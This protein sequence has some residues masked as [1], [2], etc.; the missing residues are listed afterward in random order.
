MIEEW[1]TSDADQAGAAIAATN[2]ALDRALVDG[3]P[4]V[5]AAL[6]T[7]DAVLG[8]SGIADV[9]GRDAIAGFLAR[10]GQVRAVT[11]HAVHRDELIVM[12]NRAIE[13]AWFEET[14]VPHGG[15]PIQERGRLATDWRREAD[16]VWRIARLVISDL[17]IA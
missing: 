1:L 3:T 8:E 13:F 15:V 16:G 12:G 10:G 17:P 5:A 11:F 9:V 4:E 14:K 7:K 6:F 2:R